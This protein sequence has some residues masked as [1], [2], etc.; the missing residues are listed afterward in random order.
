MVR[1][2]EQGVDGRWRKV[3]DGNSVIEGWLLQY[4]KVNKKTQIV[5]RRQK[6]AQGRYF[7]YQYGLACTEHLFLA[8]VGRQ[9]LNVRAPRDPERKRHQPH[10]GN[11]LW[12]P[13]CAG[14]RHVQWG[15][16]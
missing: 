5:V 16:D 8:E 13:H 11:K 2:T 4:T 1:A 15:D 10:E 7:D 6:D 3:P 9:L 14:S 12:C